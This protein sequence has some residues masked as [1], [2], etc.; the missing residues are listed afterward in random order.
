MDEL[1]YNLL[2]KLVEEVVDKL[3]TPV[4][5]QSLPIKVDITPTAHLRT[6]GNGQ[7]MRT[8]H[9]KRGPN[10]PGHSISCFKACLTWHE[11]SPQGPT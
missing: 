10:S 2:E 9:R 11:R 5:G 7:A 6:C 1:D 3:V 8:A 4:A